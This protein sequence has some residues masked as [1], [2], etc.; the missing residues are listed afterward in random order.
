MSKSNNMQTATQIAPS[1][2]IINPDGSIYHLKLKPEHIATNVIVVG[3]P[4]RVELISSK[5][6]KI[7]YKIQN[8]EFITHT[9]TYK[10][11]RITVIATGIGTDNIDIVLNELDAAVNIDLEK[12][13]IKEKH[14]QLNIIRIGTSGALQEDIPVD[15]F[16]AST[17]GLGL[18]GLLPFY[19]DLS[20]INE[21]EIT[22][23]FISQT[24]WNNE[25]NRPYIIKGSEEL[26]NKIAFD[27][28]KGITATANGFY[29]PQGRKLRLELQRDDLNELLNRFSYKNLRITNF[30]METSA[31][32]GL[33]KL[34]GHNTCTVCAIV[35]NR[36]AQQYSKDYKTAI[37]KLVTIVLERL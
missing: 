2:L 14:T 31:L 30:E 15:S 6:N 36:M 4:G 25:F 20:K 13:I 24:K 32:Y 27:F 29:G 34:L 8:R 28:H 10:G 19:K 22:F 3:D 5:F 37:D 7:E 1:E 12:R 35:A 23:E 33:G 26:L 9:G 18:D 11:K 21:E 16:V 17:H